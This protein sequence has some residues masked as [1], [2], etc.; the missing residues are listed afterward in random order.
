MLECCLQKN[1]AEKNDNL[2]RVIHVHQYNPLVYQQLRESKVQVVMHIYATTE[3]P[4]DKSTEL[5]LN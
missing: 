5:C 2:D 4:R 3:G 1:L